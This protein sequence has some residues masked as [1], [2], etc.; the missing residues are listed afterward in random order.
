MKFT[1]PIQMRISSLKQIQT[2]QNQVK[3]N[4]SQNTNAASQLIIQIINQNIY[5]KKCKDSNKPYYQT[6]KIFYSF[7]QKASKNLEGQKILFIFIYDYFLLTLEIFRK[8]IKQNF[9]YIC[10]KKEAQPKINF[11]TRICYMDGQMDE[12]IYNQVVETV[13]SKEVNFTKMIRISNKF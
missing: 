11:L 8:K 2:R 9:Q 7:I 10:S 5:Q 3:H 6:I 12:S 13:N 4:Y 1:K